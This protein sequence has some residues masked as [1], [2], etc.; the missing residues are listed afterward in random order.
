MNE[1]I[2]SKLLPAGALAQLATLLL[3]EV[4]TVTFEIAPGRLPG[5]MWETIG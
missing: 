5:D 2:V 3:P 1:I 4:A